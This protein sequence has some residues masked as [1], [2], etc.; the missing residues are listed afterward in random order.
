[1]E[2]NVDEIRGILVYV[3]QKEELI[4][5]QREEVLNS[6]YNDLNIRRV[7]KING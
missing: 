2:V 5:N 3:F 6:I 4:R 1:M 7:G